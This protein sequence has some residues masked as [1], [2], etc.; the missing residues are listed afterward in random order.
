[1]KKSWVYLIYFFCIGVLLYSA[2]VSGINY[3][4]DND[5]LAQAQ[6]VYLIMNGL[7]PYK[8]FFALHSSLFHW[9]LTP[10]FILKG[11]SFDAI[12]AARLLMAVFFGV[13]ILSTWLLIRTLFG[14]V[15]SFIF[16]PLFLFDPVTIFAGMQ[17][18]V[19]NASLTFY[20]LGLTLLTLSFFK[21]SEKII[22][23]SG[24]LVGVSLILSIKL[25][26]SIA[27][28]LGLYFIYSLKP[29]K[30]RNLLNLSIGFIFPIIL[31][32]FYF[33]INGGALSMFRQ[34]FIEAKA[35]IDGTLY[36]TDVGRLFFP[37]NGFIFGAYGKSFPWMYEWLL[38]ILGGAGLLRVLQLGLGKEGR[39]YIIKIAIGLSFIGS[40]LLL[41]TSVTVFTQYYLP[42]NWYSAILGAIF[43][44]S[45][46]EL[47]SNYKVIRNLAYVTL[48]LLF[49]ICTKQSISSN[50]YRS[51]MDFKSE[52]KT[53]EDRWR[54]ISEDEYTFPNFLF[55]P[56][57]YPI[58]FGHSYGDFPKSILNRMGPVEKS[59]SEKKVKYLLIAPNEF[60]LYPE[61]TKEYIEKNYRR[62]PN[63]NE[64]WLL[65]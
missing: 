38:P 55:R 26:P 33:F 40:W 62:V 36:P 13:R 30:I 45:I 27:I 60:R 32:F 48:F 16:V 5:E 7:I 22:F 65:I 25:L 2:F 12:I 24:T 57:A 10:F 14:K 23:F 21:K 58:P 19:D 1:M 8:D 35:Y 49:I 44:T 39:A 59:L 3:F 43:I 20:S 37:G 18:R 54:I 29:L 28:L 9:M 17:I 11:F 50:F 56:L 41:L 31:F 52:I 61:S 47:L 46:L 34:L 6:D 51:T 4:F 15:A 42:Q 53:F 64:L 63:D